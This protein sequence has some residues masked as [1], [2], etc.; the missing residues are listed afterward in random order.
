MKKINMDFFKQNKKFLILS[1]IL[2]ITNFFIC[3]CFSNN[4]LNKK[5][6]FCISSIILEIIFMFFLIKSEKKKYKIEKKFFVIYLIL[7]IIYM[8]SIPI[9]RVPDE[10]NHFLRAYEITEGNVISQQDEKTKLAGNDLPSNI[11]S[12][13]NDNFSEL[14]KNFSV[15]S[16]NKKDFISFTNTSLYSPIS[17]FPQCLGIFIGKIFNLSFV[18]QAYLGRIFNFIFFLVIMFFS[19]K[20]MPFKKNLLMFICFL[21]ITLQEAVSLSPDAITIA[22][23]SALISFVMYMKYI[24]TKTMNKIDYILLCILPIFLAM[25]KIV[26]L[27]LCLLLFLIPKERFGSLKKKNIIIGLLAIIVILMNLIWTNQVSSFLAANLH[28]S[29]S[30]KQIEFIINNPIRYGMIVFRSFDI[31]G[32]F[33]IFNMMGRYLS[34]FDVNVFS[35]YIYISIILMIFLIFITEKKEKKIQ[36]IDKYLMAFCFGATI[37]LIFTSIYIQWSSYML[38]FVDGV[39]GRYFIPIIII[40]GLI[41]SNFIKIK[42]NENISFNLILLF[43]IFENISAIIALFMKFI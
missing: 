35:I 22:S 11:S 13:D 15:K 42:N 31:N 19:I 5:I 26:Y 37:I 18:L 24:K 41:F 43:L 9:G 27:P 21:P 16:N 17:Y 23:A 40:V 8:I 14:K 28:G 34:F 25:S 20:F 38:S 6:V 33:Y 29:D 30:S 32:D 2:I 36:K 4:S 10:F 39:Q 7:G 12:V 1:F 3:F